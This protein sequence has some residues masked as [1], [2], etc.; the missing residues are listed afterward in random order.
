MFAAALALGLL[1]VAFIVLL[2]LCRSTK[3]CASCRR[4]DEDG[5]PS[6]A[7]ALPTDTGAGAPAPRRMIISLTGEES[8]WAATRVA[9][10]AATIIAT[11]SG[12]GFVL[13]A[14]DERTAER[15]AMV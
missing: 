6:T 14:G 10:G 2:L 12:G 9:G 5:A 13:Y 4:S 3:C 7:D 8:G 15:S 1:S 11:S